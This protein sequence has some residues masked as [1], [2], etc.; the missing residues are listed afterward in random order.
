MRV[1]R[2]ETRQPSERPPLPEEASPDQEVD[3]VRRF[4]DRLRLLGIRRLGDA[5]LAEDLAQETLRRVTEAQRA[6]RIE[7]PD[8]LPAFVFRTATHLCLHLYRSRGREARALERL[9]RD[10]GDEGLA[11]DA[12]DRIVTDET[13]QEVREAM[14]QLGADDRDLLRRAYYVGEDSEVIARALQLTAGAV[15]VRKHRALAR[16]AS[17]LRS[18]RG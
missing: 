14:A 9:G 6:G 2:E 13:R 17:L 16:L 12:L 8:A 15:R 18:C 11:A 5:S 1:W 10:T 7:H 3:L 4:W